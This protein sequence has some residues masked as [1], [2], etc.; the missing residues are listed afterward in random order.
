MPSKILSAAITGLDAQIVEVEV[1]VSFGLRSFNIVGLADKEVQE[2]KER[3]GVALKNSGFSSP[4]KEAIRV[5]V[6]L[7]PASLKK[8][9][10]LYDLPIALGFLLGNKQTEFNPEKDRKSVV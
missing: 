8:E 9:G 6:N 7:A 10:T 1:D 2:A 5:L 4:S 3:V